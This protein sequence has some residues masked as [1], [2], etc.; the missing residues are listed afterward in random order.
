M[1][2]TLPTD[3]PRD[4]L[5]Q[6]CQALERKLG[7][8]PYWEIRNLVCQI[9]CNRIRVQG[10]VSSFYEKQIA[11]AGGQSRGTGTHAQRN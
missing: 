6:C 3:L 1:A 4:E 8:S 9:D 11:Q 10:T 7:A 5:S 2:P